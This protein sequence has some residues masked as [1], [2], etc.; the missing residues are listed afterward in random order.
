M[1]RP[2]TLTALVLAAAASMASAQDAAPAI[3]I[4]GEREH[5]LAALD[6]MPD[7]PLRARFLRCAR[8]SSERLLDFGEAVPCAM[9]WDALLK[10]GFNG[11]VH[12]LLAWWRAHR[13]DAVRH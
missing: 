3:A 11:E 4:L 6:A 12:A 13:D 1:K 8:D 5:L 9:T 7:A 10:R 2:P